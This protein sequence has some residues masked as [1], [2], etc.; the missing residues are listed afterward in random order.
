MHGSNVVLHMCFIYFNCLGS[1]KTKPTLFKSIFAKTGFFFYI[2]CDFLLS[3]KHKMHLHGL[4]MCAYSKLLT[5]CVSAQLSSL[6]RCDWLFVCSSPLLCGLCTFLTESGWQPE[7]S[8][9]FLCQSAAKVKA[10]RSP[11]IFS[12][13]PRPLWPG[14]SGCWQP[15]G[16]IC[17]CKLHSFSFALLFLS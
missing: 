1:L 11:G 12:L 7:S 5:Q 13:L 6:S 9:S 3:F 17:Y 16:E 15:S 4:R 2:M 10:H 8:Q 14:Q